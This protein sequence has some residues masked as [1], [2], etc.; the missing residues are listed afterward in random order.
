MFSRN[1]P[2]VFFATR[3]WIFILLCL[4]LCFTGTAWWLVENS[5]RQNIELQFSHLTKASEQALHNRLNSYLQ[6]LLGAKGFFEGSFQITRAEWRQYALALDLVSSF[7]GING[8]GVINDVPDEHI[9]VFTAEVQKTLPTFKPYPLNQSFENYL[10]NFIEPIE[11]NREAVGLNIAFESH[12]REAA[13]LSAT[14]GRAAITKRILLVQDV[15]KTPGFLLLLPISAKTARL[16]AIEQFP[17]WIFA[18]FIAR[19]FLRNLTAHQGQDFRLEIFDGVPSRHTLLYDSAEADASPHPGQFVVEKTVEVMQQKWLVRWTSTEAFEVAAT[20]KAPFFVLLF[21]LVFTLLLAIFL[22]F[23]AV[24]SELA[25]YQR[26]RATPALG[27]SVMLFTMMSVG[28]VLLYHQLLNWEAEQIKLTA[29]DKIGNVKNALISRYRSYDKLMNQSAHFWHAYGFQKETFRESWGEA[30]KVHQSVGEGVYAFIFLNADLDTIES[31]YQISSHSDLINK[32]DKYIE[33]YLK[34]RLKARPKA[35]LVADLEG[36]GLTKSAMTVHPVI[37]RDE[38]QGY[39]LAMINVEKFIAP[40]INQFEFPDDYNLRLQWADKVLTY[41][42]LNNTDDK[43]HENIKLGGATWTLT[44]SQNKVLLEKAHSFLPTLVLLIGFATALLMTMVIYFIQHL[45]V[46]ARVI[47]EKENLLSTF[48][49]NVPMSVAMFDQRFRYMVASQSWYN[50]YQLHPETTFGKP[51]PPEKTP[52]W[53]NYATNIGNIQAS[54]S[55]LAAKELTKIEERVDHDDGSLKAWM[56][57]IICHWFD[58]Q[59]QIGGVIVFA[60]NITEEKNMALMKNEFISTVSHE[61]RTPLTAIQGALGL[62]QMGAMQ[63][64]EAKYQRLVQSSFDNCQNL[65]NIVNDI[66]DLEKIAAGQLEY[67]FTQVEL[68]SLMNDVIQLNAGYAERCKVHFIFKP[69]QRQIYA[70]VDKGRLIQCLGNLMSNAAKF[71]HERG[72][73]HI[74]LRQ[75]ASQIIIDVED[76]GVGIPQAFQPK[77][78]TRFAQADSASTRA[79]GGTGL[80]LAITKTMIEGMGGEISFSSKINVGTV[81]TIRLPAYPQSK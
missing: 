48:V 39:L 59:G 62:L 41:G 1:T 32:M 51:H 75:Q 78:F 28:A 18:P 20:D 73:V 76:N 54:G 23:A 6:I 57:Y 31:S 38:V 79:K 69:P 13:M 9:N 26:R 74:G 16:E 46:N 14:T 3:Y 34:Q 27:L 55:E 67:Q 19:N 7:P 77:I 25:A 21:G 11:K 24:K 81:F 33:K 68:V 8:I 15:E 5:Q 58:D 64:L 42:Q 40:I 36:T 49:S 80:G 22:H 70:N 63:N 50:F 65:T 53:L 45:K 56:R 17:S 37:I 12:R 30:I 72:L 29:L 52:A 35:T 43:Y 10:I 2:G 71:S 60:E 44:I 47:G 66:L 61:L 4:P